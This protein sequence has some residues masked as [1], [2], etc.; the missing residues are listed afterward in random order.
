MKTEQ[1]DQLLYE[2]ES[3]CLDFKEMQ[4]KFEN[5]SND[6]KSE[7]LKDIIGFANAWRRTEAYILIGVREEEDGI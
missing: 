7:I 3:V 4:Y 5:A 6:D 2:S 1:L